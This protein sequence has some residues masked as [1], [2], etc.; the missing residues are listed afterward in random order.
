MIKVMVPST[1]SSKEREKSA[2]EWVPDR[3]RVDGRYPVWPR[4]FINLNHG[5][6]LDRQEGFCLEI[7]DGSWIAIRAYGSVGVFIDGQEINRMGREDTLSIGE[8]ITVRTHVGR[9]YLSMREDSKGCELTVKEGRREVA[10]VRLERVTGAEADSIKAAEARVTRMAW[11][12]VLDGTS[13]FL[14]PGL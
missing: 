6:F 7:P 4:E 8:G 9:T 13:D 3:P 14:R 10:R 1:S 2:P 11:G 12:D 5:V